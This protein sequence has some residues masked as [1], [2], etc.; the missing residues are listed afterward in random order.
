MTGTVL[1]TDSGTVLLS[2][3]GTV[4]LTDSGTVLLID[5]GTVL[6]T[7]S[8]TVLLHKVS[9]SVKSAGR[10]IPEELSFQIEI[11]VVSAMIELAWIAQSV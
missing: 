4:L 6:L 9:K 7:D 1:L 8:G 11:F 2:D 5:S 3:S 10:R